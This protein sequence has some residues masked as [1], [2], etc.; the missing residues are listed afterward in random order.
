MRRL[1]IS[2]F[3]LLLLSLVGIYVFIPRTIS[4]SKTA[5]VDC[6][7]DGAARILLQP[8]Q[9]KK[10]WVNNTI[11]ADQAFSIKNDAFVYKEAAYKITRLS[12]NSVDLTIDKGNSKTNSTLQFFPFN[13]DSV[14]IIWKASLASGQ[15]PFGK[16]QRYWQAISIK[17]DMTNILLNLHSFLGNKENIYGINIQKTSTTDTLLVAA[18]SVSQVY[19]NQEMIYNSINMLTEFIAKKGALQTGAPMLNITKVNNNQYQ[20]MVA[21]P[22]NVPLPGEGNVFLRRMIR[23]SFLVT[24]V[25]GGINAV[26]NAT[27]NMEN[28]IADYKKTVMAIP[29]QSLLTDRSKETDSAKWI[30]KIYFPVYY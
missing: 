30:T 12:R 27:N 3:I 28:Y 25:K 23:G 4:I 17:K 15:N 8:G 9:W 13:A 2:F 6:N 26:N 11:F 19:P 29:F 14:A 20:Y 16:V 18:K 10:W 24:E 7:I 1:I 22:T 21:V 5:Y